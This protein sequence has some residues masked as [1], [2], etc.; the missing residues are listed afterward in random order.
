MRLLIVLLL[1][2]LLVSC[3]NKA[4]LMENCADEDYL[5]DYDKYAEGF[6]ALASH[7]YKQS[8]FVESVSE[9]KVSLQEKLKYN[10]DAS[11]NYGP[12]EKY[13]RDCEKYFNQNPE[14]FKQ[15]YR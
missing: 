15:K 7:W 1:P 3:S 13:Y 11:P 6:S 9:G 14:T 4:K 10:P 8:D 2:L 5:K 12:Y